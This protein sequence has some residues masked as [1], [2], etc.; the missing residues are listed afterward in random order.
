MARKLVSASTEEAANSRF[1]RKGE[2]SLR[3]FV[4][5]FPDT[6]ATVRQ[7]SKKT[8]SGRKACIEL[9]N[10]KGSVQATAWADKG[11]DDKTIIKMAK[12][13]SISIATVYDI[14]NSR[15]LYFIYDRGTSKDL[16]F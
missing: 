9:V 10:E 2:V 5:M 15:D 11:V 16:V 8:K 12:A 3:E 6:K 7:L 13:G 14:D 4:D 1:E